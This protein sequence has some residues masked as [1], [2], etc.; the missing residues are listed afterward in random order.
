MSPNVADISRNCACGSSSSGTCQA[1]PRSGFGVEVEL[2]H[3]DES[4]VGARALAQRDV[5]E[6]LG[7]AA[8][9]RGVGLTDASP[10]SIPTSVAPNS[11]TRAKNF[12]HQRLDRAV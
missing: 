11:A 6:H 8:D 5:R 2:V 12:A 4:D 9:D 10:V 3:H 1:Q 7:G